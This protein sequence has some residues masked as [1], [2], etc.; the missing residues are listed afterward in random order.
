MRGKY[1]TNCQ[2]NYKV[3]ILRSRLCDYGDAYTLV[4]ENITF[5]RGLADATDATKQRNKQGKKVVFKNCAPFT[6][7]ISETNNTQ[8]ANAKDL[9]NSMPI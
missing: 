4:R 6:D 8:I 3:S 2:I 9:D 7:C 5:I 1:N